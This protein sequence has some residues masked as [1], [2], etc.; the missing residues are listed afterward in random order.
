MRPAGFLA[1]VEHGEDFRTF[2]GFAVVDAERKAGG[3]HPVEAGMLGM[4][5]VGERNPLDISP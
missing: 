3:Q 5:A 4:D 2:C 1:Q